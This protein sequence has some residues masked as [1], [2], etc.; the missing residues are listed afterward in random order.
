[1]THHHE[2]FVELFSAGM[3]DKRLDALAQQISREFDFVTET[4]PLVVIGVLK[5]SFIFLADLVRKLTIPVEIEFVRVTSYGQ[6]QTSSG[7]PEILFATLNDFTGRDVLVV[8]DIVDTGYT[9][10]TLLKYLRSLGAN[11]IKVCTLL[12]KPAKRQMQVPVDYIGFE[13]A[14]QFTFGYGL[15]VAECYREKNGIYALEN[16][17]EPQS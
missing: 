17:P 12:D 15:D 1:M 11:R 2:T 13:V 14:P 6:S 3:I 9:V 7:K 16:L 5:G 8:E 4:V 10:D